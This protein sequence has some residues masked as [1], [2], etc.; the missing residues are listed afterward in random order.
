MKDAEQLLLEAEVFVELHMYEDAWNRIE[1]IAPEDKT[2][3]S[4]LVL[5]LRILTALSQWD[6]GH[7]IARLLHRS[8][9]KEDPLREFVA[10]FYH[11][12]ARCCAELNSYEEA[13]KWMRSASEAWKDIR[14]KLVDDESLQ[15]A[16]W[17]EE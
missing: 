5:R 16:L 6:L 13:R 2:E 11:A 10:R 1:E 9:A 7:E 4:V 14:L 17:S 12:R 8:F 15:A 3:A